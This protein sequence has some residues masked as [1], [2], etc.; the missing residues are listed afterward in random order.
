MAFNFQDDQTGSCDLFGANGGNI[1]LS[2]DFRHEFSGI[3]HKVMWFR[4]S[5]NCQWFIPQNTVGDLPLNRGDYFEITL[6]ILTNNMM[7]VNQ[8]GL[9]KYVCARVGRYRKTGV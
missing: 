3:Q 4:T 7:E 5:N 1:Y 9:R 6:R 2:L 8:E